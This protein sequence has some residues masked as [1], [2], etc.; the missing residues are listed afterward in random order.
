MVDHVDNLAALRQKVSVP[1]LASERLFTRM[2]YL[3]LFAAHG[4]DIAMVDLSWTGGLTEGRKIAALA[5]AHRLPV[6]THNCGGPVLTRACAHFNLS[7]INAIEQETVR[8]IYRT[9]PDLI[10]TDIGIEN[11]RIYVDDAPGLGVEFMP[12][13]FGRTDIV[14]RD[15]A[16]EEAI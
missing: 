5:D 14:R 4:A 1:I 11:G 9:F 6:T 3:P 15:S 10:S 7:T 2:Q 13:V 8:A 16:I 12:E